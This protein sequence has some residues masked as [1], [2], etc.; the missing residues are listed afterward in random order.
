M[1]RAGVACGYLSSTS[2]LTSFVPDPLLGLPRPLRSSCRLWTAPDDA[3]ENPVTDVDSDADVY[4]D[5]SKETVDDD[6]PNADF[7]ANLP[8]IYMNDYYLSL[9]G[10]AYALIVVVAGF[11]WYLAVQTYSGVLGFLEKYLDVVIDEE[12][13]GIVK[14]NVLLAYVKQGLTGNIPR[15]SGLENLPSEQ[16][17]PLIYAANHASWMDVTGIAMAVPRKF[18]FIAKEEAAG[19]RIVG[20]G[21]RN[22]RALLVNRE[23]RKSQL[24]LF[25]RS[26]EVLKK[27]IDIIAFPEGT[28]SKDGRLTSFGKAGIFAMARKANAFVVPVSITGTQ[29]VMPKEALM[30]VRPGG[31][32]MEIH[33][34]KPVSPEG[35]TEEEM[36]EKVW[37]QVAR[38]LPQRQKPL[39]PVSAP[40]T[41]VP[42]QSGSGRS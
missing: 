17:S 3:G 33:F 31:S 2:F 23:D 16:T 36:Q 26:L 10:M 30:P 40:S 25:R 41:P 5:R 18:K 28:R 39:P 6:I 29:L 13:H 11:F 19:Y 20:A 4:F 14:L 34:H 21:V 38:G 27:N 22:A 35:L 7:Y 37:K 24:K 8:R 1:L 12:R 42:T 9:F 15:I 32:L